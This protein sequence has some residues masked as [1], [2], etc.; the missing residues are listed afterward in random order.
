MNCASAQAFAEAGFPIIPVRLAP[1]PNGGWRKEPLAKW[2]LATTDETTIGR[3]W[4]QW[5][6]AL[7]GIPLQR[8]HWA[9][10]DADRHAGGVD[11]VAQV[12]NLGALG[13]HCKIA[14]PS[15]GLHLVFAQPDPPIT[16]RFNWCEGVEILGEGCL[17]TCY[18][19]EE[20]KFPRIAPRAILPEMFWKPRDA[21][22]RERFLIKKTEP[23]SHDPVLVADYVEALRKLNPVDWRDYAEWFALMTGANYVGISERDWIEWSTG[24][25]VYAADGAIIRKMWRK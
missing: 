19:L 12:T 16:G 21:Q 5:P 11:G 23:A 9:V 7:P 13:P 15:G 1:K 14:T 20:L 22:C 2:S 6:D 8:M 25:P 18:D 17:L 4:S 24:D 3:W 10:V